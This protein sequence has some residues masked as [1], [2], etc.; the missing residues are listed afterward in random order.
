M[1]FFLFLRKGKWF[2][3][4]HW[5]NECNHFPY[6]LFYYNSSI[7]KRGN[8][9]LSNLVAISFHCAQFHYESCVLVIKYLK[10]EILFR[11]ADFPIQYTLNYPIDTYILLRKMHRRSSNLGRVLCKM[12]RRSSN[13]GRVLSRSSNFQNAHLGPQTC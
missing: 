5:D 13:L 4:I 6:I 9:G 12:H 2:P 8:F 3:F 11:A 10:C 1:L 7:Y